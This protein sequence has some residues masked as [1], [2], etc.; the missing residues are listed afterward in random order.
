VYVAP[1]ATPAD[2]SHRESVLAGID[3]YSRGSR[4]TDRLSIGGDDPVP[5]DPDPLT[6]VAD[7]SG[8][9]VE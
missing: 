2:Y 9:S 5:F 4:E 1:S 3:R 7:E 6:T 8:R